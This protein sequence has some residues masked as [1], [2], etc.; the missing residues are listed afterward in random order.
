MQN[1]FSVKKINPLGKTL[2]KKD[3][4]RLLSL[5]F[6]ESKEGFVI[7]LEKLKEKLRPT[8]IKNELQEV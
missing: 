2:S 8:T 1:V 4:L 6:K 5:G 3:S 7:E